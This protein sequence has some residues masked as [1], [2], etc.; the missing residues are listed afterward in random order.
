MTE[1]TTQNRI[2]ID[3]VIKAAIIIF[4]WATPP[5]ISKAFV[6][7]QASFPGLFFG[8]L[9]YLLGALSLFAIIAI[10]G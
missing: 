1:T 7:N 3:F 4:F 2:S 5:L 9:R 8:F 10:R 6:G